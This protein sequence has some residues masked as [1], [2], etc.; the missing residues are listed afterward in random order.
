MQQGFILEH[1]KAVRWVAGAPETS[2]SGDIKAGGRQHRQIESYRCVGCGYLESYA[3]AEIS[4]V[5]ARAGF[6]PCSILDALDPPCLT[7]SVRL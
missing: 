5:Q 2:F 4:V 6:R 7:T 3:Q 1:R